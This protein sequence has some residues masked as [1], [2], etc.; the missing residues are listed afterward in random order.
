MKGEV[1]RLM[2]PIF[3]VVADDFTGASDAASFLQ[4]QGL[5]TVLS[6]GIPDQEILTGVEADAIVIALKT[7]TAPV[8]EAVAQSEAAFDWLTANG[9]DKLYFKYCSTF[10]S[11]DEGNIGPVIDRMLEKLG[12][13]YTFLSPA[14]PVNGRVVRDGHLYVNGVP[15]HHSSMKDHPLTPMWD[16]FLPTLMKHQS[17]YPSLVLPLTDDFAANHAA[18][19]SLLETD[20]KSA[21]HLTLVPDYRDE[22]DA[23]MISRLFGG[24]R[25]YTGGSGILAALGR[26]WL[27]DKGIATSSST[28]FGGA[29]GKAII[30]AG[31]CSAATNRQVAAYQ[32]AG[33]HAI[34]VE[35]PLLMESADYGRTVI[36]WA[37]RTPGDLLVYSSQLP[38]EMRENQLRYGADILSAKIEGL[39]HQLALQLRD[40]DVTKIIVAGGETSG[41]V[42]QALGFNLFYIG[43]AMAPGV[44]VMIPV[45]QPALRIVLKSGNFGGEYFF[46]ETIDKLSG[47]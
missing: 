10:D 36:E 13:R 25:F 31:S 8:A 3:G 18:L 38:D 46:Q 9:A 43:D 11:T 29:A 19:A 35:P 5:R 27:R 14:L 12:Q 45:E 33:G 23:K 1:E 26:A 6:S 2:R 28:E 47:G 34:K 7:R 37:L 15:L 4:M 40:T 39:F 30:L 22:D 17:R 20:A 42:T 24:L 16:S 41:T 32:A 21:P 44:P